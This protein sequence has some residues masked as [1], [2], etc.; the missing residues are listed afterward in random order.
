MI[1]ALVQE[2]HCTGRLPV[3]S[4][5]M[6]CMVSGYTEPWTS[7]MMMMMREG[8][9]IWKGVR[10]G[11]AQNQRGKQTNLKCATTLLIRQCRESSRC[12]GNKSSAS[13]GDRLVIPAHRVNL[14]PLA[15][16][17]REGPFELVQANISAR[18]FAVV[19]DE[20]H[21]CWGRGRDLSSWCPARG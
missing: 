14:S 17:R 18:G 1:R 15:V 5:V 7:L 13:D 8:K 9:S 20:V 3:R 10:R 2:L 21:A 16:L 6:C 12:I 4:M 11:R 19:E